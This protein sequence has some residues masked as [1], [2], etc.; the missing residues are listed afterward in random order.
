[1]SKTFQIPCVYCGSIFKTPVVVESFCSHKCEM[2]YWG[3][4]EEIRKIEIESEC[5]QCHKPYRRLIERI[6]LR[7]YQALLMCPNC[8]VG[9][10]IT[11][12]GSNKVWKNEQR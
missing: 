2:D 3:S 8:S 6:E 1:M 5:P 4:P 7:N 9:D 11:I 12:I 10:S